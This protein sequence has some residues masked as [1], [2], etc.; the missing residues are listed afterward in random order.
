MTKLKTALV[1][2]IL[3][4]ASVTG[5]KVVLRH[6]NELKSANTDDTGKSADRGISRDPRIQGFCHCRLSHRIL[7]K[8][9]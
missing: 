5:G 7:V 6:S 1:L 9:S 2:I 4:T 8:E 3:L